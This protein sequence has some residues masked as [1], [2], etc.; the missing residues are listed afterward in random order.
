MSESYP[1]LHFAREH[2]VDYGDVLHAVD[3]MRGRHLDQNAHWQVC[4]MTN[5]L[6][7][8]MACLDLTK[9][10]ANRHPELIPADQSLDQFNEAIER[11]KDYCHLDWKT[12]CARLQR[13]AE[14]GEIFA[15]LFGVSK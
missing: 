7:N 1:Y 8:E 9:L 10:V 5:L 13:T 15:V 2:G 3:L 6:P 12:M 14:K 4:A 11:A